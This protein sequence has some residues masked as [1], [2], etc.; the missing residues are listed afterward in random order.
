MEF[1]KSAF[2]EFGS[3]CKAEVNLN[4]WLHLLADRPGPTNGGFCTIMLAGL[5]IIKTALLML[6]NS[7]SFSMYRIY[8]LL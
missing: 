6:H 8:T 5:N 4:P 2:V 3:R 7:V 1:L